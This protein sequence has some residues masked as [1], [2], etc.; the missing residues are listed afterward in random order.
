MPGSSPTAISDTR[1]IQAMQPSSSAVGMMVPLA[2]ARPPILPGSTVS[3][4][5]SDPGMLA[6]IRSLNGDSYLLFYWNSSG[7]CTYISAMPEKRAAREEGLRAGNEMVDQ[8]IAAGVWN[9][10]DF[11]ALGA[12]TREL[13]GEE[14]AQIMARLSAAINADRVRF[15]RSQRS[16]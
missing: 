7:Q 1:A 5:T 16:P 10:S 15:D 4:P 11:A 3:V 9:P 13:S 14:R 2:I 8:A 6:A 12:A